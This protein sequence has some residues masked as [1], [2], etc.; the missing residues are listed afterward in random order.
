MCGVAD[1]VAV[2]FVVASGDGE[3]ARSVAVARSVGA[4]VA[5]G[6]GVA[7]ALVAG[8]DV[9]GTGTSVGGIGTA[10]G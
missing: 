5:F 4:T 1:G 2:P 8:A 10:V 7:G 9:G 3:A 6:R